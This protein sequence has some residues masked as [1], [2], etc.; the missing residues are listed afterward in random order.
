ML[1]CHA[2]GPGSFPGRCTRLLSREN[3]VFRTYK[4]RTAPGNRTEK[5]LHFESWST[6]CCEDD[7]GDSYVHRLRCCQVCGVP[8][9][10]LLLCA[11]ASEHGRSSNLQNGPHL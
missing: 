3:V 4:Q 2:G 10:C 1:A 9:S 7:L 11:G 8:E 6:T 5:H